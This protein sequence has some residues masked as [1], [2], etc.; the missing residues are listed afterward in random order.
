MTSFF[1]G[2]CLYKMICVLWIFSFEGEKLNDS[3]ICGGFSKPCFLITKILYF[4]FLAPRTVREVI[5]VVVSHQVC[6]YLL[7]QPQEIRQPCRGEDLCLFKDLGRTHGKVM[8]S[9]R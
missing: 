6:G 3:L 7:Q 4:R 1:S 9:L 5:S 2:L 8:S